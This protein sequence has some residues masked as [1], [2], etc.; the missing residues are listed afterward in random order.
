M[1]KTLAFLLCLLLCFTAATAEDDAE[2]VPGGHGGI[3]FVSYGVSG[4]MENNYYNLT[5][6]P[7][8]QAESILSV[9]EYDGTEREVK[10]GMNVLEELGEYLESTGPESWAAR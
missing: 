1:K 8:E 4:G 10:L 2:A 7:G 5:I 3:L 9:H 6:T